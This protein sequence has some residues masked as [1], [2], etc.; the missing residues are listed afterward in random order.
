[1]YVPHQTFAVQCRSGTAGVAGNS[2]DHRIRAFLAGE[3]HGE[4]VLAA[5]Y[6]GVA[7][8]PIPARLLELFKR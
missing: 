4:D 6:G 5:L 3:G 2:V 7:N 8:E 1:M